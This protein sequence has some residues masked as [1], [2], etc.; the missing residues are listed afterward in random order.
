MAKR[1]TLQAKNLG[2]T[3]YTVGII[4]AV[5]AAIGT[6]LNANWAQGQWPILLLILIGLIVGFRNISAGESSSFLI[7]TVTLIIAA[8]SAELISIDALIPRIGTF[9]TAALSNFIVLVAT[10]AVVVSFKAVYNIAK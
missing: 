6:A 2:S 8:A 4:I 5:I 1:A 7:G 9:I 3:L 10:A